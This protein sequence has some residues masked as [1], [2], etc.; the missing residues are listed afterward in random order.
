MTDGSRV[1]HAKTWSFSPMARVVL[2][3][4]ALEY[5]CHGAMARLFSR[6][7]LVLQTSFSEIK[8]QAAEQPFVL[9]GTPGSLSVRDVKGRGFYYRQFYDAQGNKAADYV[10]PVHDVG[11]LERAAAIRAQIGLANALSKEV[12]I[13]A[14]RGYVRADSRTNAVL[15][16]LANRNLFRGGAMLVGSHAYGALLNELGVRAAAFFTEDVDIARG[17]PLEVARDEDF[18]RVLA[19]STV[20]L[21]PVPSFDRTGFS[22]SYKAKG[23]DRFR[24]DLLVPTRGSEVTTRSIPELR[25]HA[26]ALPHLGYLL[27]GPLEAVVLGRESIVPVRVPRPELFA[28]HK[29]LVSQLRSGT[30]DKTRKDLIQA[31]VLF[32]VLAEDAPDALRSAFAALSRSARTKA[33]AGARVVLHQIE[34]AG[35]ERSAEWMKEILRGE[36]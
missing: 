7:S 9:V 1:R 21:H 31:S 36:S 28:W 32:A 12:R 19:E 14:Q 26:T 8:R 15:A 6:Y 2:Y 29:M 23:Q 30:G 25:A 3:N 5:N 24:V 34:A 18:A 4:G 17:G 27:D 13:L 16:A 20:P 35:H 10:G 33:R 11:A 22:T